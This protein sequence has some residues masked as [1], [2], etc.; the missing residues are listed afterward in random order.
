MR[1]FSLP[2]ITKF[3]NTFLSNMYHSPINISDIT[4]YD[5]IVNTVEHAYQGMKTMMH[6]EQMKIFTCLSPYE[7]KKLGKKCMVRP[8][9]DT[10]KY[11]IM[12]R[13]L[14]KKF[15]DYVLK[16]ALLSTFPY[17]LIEGNNWGD[18][19]WGYDV[20]LGKGE[21]NLGKLLMQLRNQY[22]GQS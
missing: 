13:L 22:R 16:E 6:N 14:E 3:S 7:A 9:W 4:G 19:F 17:Y 11:D 10:M 18:T 15:S 21:N 5:I 12:K 2:V 8:A 1:E 20:N